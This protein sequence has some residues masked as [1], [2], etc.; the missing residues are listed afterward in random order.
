[1]GIILADLTLFDSDYRAA[2][3]TFD[4]LVQAAGRA[5]RGDKPG[6]V[7]IQTYSRII[8]P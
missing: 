4:L 1:M 8:M 5:G 7:I 6:D 2:E 3:R